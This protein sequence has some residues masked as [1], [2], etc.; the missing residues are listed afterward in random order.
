MRLLIPLHPLQRFRPI[1]RA[2]LRTVLPATLAS[3]LLMPTVAFA[4]GDILE[5]HRPL[6][7]FDSRTGLVS[8]DAAALAE[9]DSLAA[10]VRWNRFGTP[11]V[12]LRPDGFLSL[13][14]AGDPVVAARGWIREHRVLFR[15][16]DSGVDSLTVLRVSRLADSDA[17]VVLFGQR[18]GAL[19]LVREGRIKVGLADGQVFWV[20]SSAV[21]D[22]ADPGSP[23]LTATDAWL[24]AAGDLGLSFLPSDLTAA[25]QDHGWSLFEVP[26]LSHLQRVRP[27]ALALPGAGAVP[28][29]ETIVLDVQAGRA[30]A[31]TSFVDG[32][33]GEVLVRHNRTWRLIGTE[34]FPVPRWRTFAANPRLDRSSVDTRL[35]GCWTLTD[36]DGDPIPGCDLE[37]DNPVARAPWDHDFLTGTPTFTTSGNAARSALSWASP[38]TPSVPLQPVSLN[39]SYDFP[40]TNH[41]FES[42]CDPA[43]IPLADTDAAVTHLFVAHNRM[44]DWA[45]PLGFTEGNGNAQVHNFGLTSADR[46]NDPEVGN[47]QAGALTGGFPGYLGRN[48]ANQITLND[49]IAPITNMYL[50]QPIAGTAYPPCADGDYDLAIVGHEYGHLIQNRMVDPDNGL[51]G[52]QGRAMGESWSDLTAVEFLN[53]FDLVPVGSENPFA[54][55]AYAT[56]DELAGLRN[57][58]MNDSPLNFSNLDYDPAGLVSESPH[59]NGEIWS[60]VNFDIRQALIDTYDATHPASDVA[61]Q[62]RCAEGSEP[63]VD[64]P[65]NRRWVQIF[66]D[67]FLLMPSTP[68]MLDARDA[69]LAADRARAADPGWD[70]NQTELWRAFAARG[71]GR[72]AASD[73]PADVDPTPSFASPLGGNAT[74]TFELTARDEGR[75][76]VAGEI[77]IGRYQARSRPVA[78]TDPATGP[79]ATAE[80]VAGAY[81][82]V[83]RADG[84]GHA[85][86]ILRVDAGDL[87]TVSIPLAT[88]WASIHKG[89]TAVG[90]GSD[91]SSL[92][93][94]SETTTWQHLG[95]TPDVAGSTV[96]VTLNGRKTLRRAQVSAMIEPDEDRFEALRAFD[97]QV[98]DASVS[99][100][101]C[102]LATD[103]TTIFSSAPNAFPGSGFRPTI[104]DGELRSFDLPTTRATHLRLVVRSNQCTGNPQYQDPALDN[105]PLNETDCRLGSAVLAPRNRDVTAAELQ[106]FSH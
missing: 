96:T 64:C 18:A 32:H 84:Y 27:V 89:A 3:L 104:G 77:Y 101:S 22:V 98:C 50:W 4:A 40:W 16:S 81:E 74:V 87:R 35:L 71:L 25:G 88:N 86:R 31:Y 37:L 20:S 41:W 17:Q 59:A 46:E 26:G 83:V 39:R 56:G 36:L 90:D 2:R 28:A 91:L 105:D 47:A 55:G 29:F 70:S 76:P 106:V 66:H 78:D 58:P 73:G 67:A 99:V 85:R 100:T 103:Y 8:P 33:T 95:A 24:A 13:S 61:L 97:L 9:V 30:T 102:S 42:R 7:D 10:T 51:A 92:L 23:A 49:G 48:N 14:P 38:Q 79:G 72:D 54:V 5:A 63:A 6:P 93:D 60:A 52:D 80:L 44:H 62:R 82:L 45:Y 57:F 1:A 21:G 65:G 75:V 11:R 34:V 69:Y 43:S 94:D 68:T 12:L 15:L 19:E 53:G